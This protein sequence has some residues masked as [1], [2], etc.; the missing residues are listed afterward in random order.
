MKLSQFVLANMIVKTLFYV[1]IFA[2]PI[3]GLISPFSTKFQIRSHLL[4]KPL[5]TTTLLKPTPNDWASQNHQLNDFAK[6]ILKKSG[7]IVKTSLINHETKRNYPKNEKIL[8]K[9]LIIPTSS[10]FQKW[11]HLKKKPLK[12]LT[13]K[14]TEWVSLSSKTFHFDI[15]YNWGLRYGFFLCWACFQNGC[16]HK[17]NQNIHK[18]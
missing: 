15:G 9:R 5:T 4:N 11:N 8:K 7:I 14:R 17:S 10:W 6:E 1:S 2:I 16:Q 12:M 3:F 18:S 13:P